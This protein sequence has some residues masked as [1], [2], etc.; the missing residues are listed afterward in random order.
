MPMPTKMFSHI[1]TYSSTRLGTAGTVILPSASARRCSRRAI[2]SRSTDASKGLGGG[3]STRLLYT[4]GPSPAIAYKSASR[5]DSG[6]QASKHHG[7]E[8][9]ADLGQRVASA[10]DVP[11]VNPVVHTEY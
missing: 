4:T 1:L 6:K 5:A 2:A 7:G 8:G 10:G 3:S 11:A 9:I